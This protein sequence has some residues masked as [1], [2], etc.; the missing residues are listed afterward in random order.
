[1]D[2]PFIDTLPNFSSSLNAR[3]EIPVFSHNSFSVEVTRG[4]K[5]GG[6]GA[7]TNYSRTHLY[8]QGVVPYLKNSVLQDEN[9][10]SQGA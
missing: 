6:K 1:M 4:Q 8:L 9:L 10:G 7:A 3:G 5:H 2:F